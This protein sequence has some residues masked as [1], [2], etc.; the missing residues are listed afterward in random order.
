MGK[1][2]Y[3]ISSF[4]FLQSRTSLFDRFIRDCKNIKEILVKGKEVE[5]DIDI[6]LELARLRYPNVTKEHLNEK[7]GKH[8]WLVEEAVTSL[9]T[10]YSQ[11]SDVSHFKRIQDF[12][13]QANVILGL[14]DDV[15]IRVQILENFCWILD[16]ILRAMDDKYP[17]EKEEYHMEKIQQFCFAISKMFMPLYDDTS[18]CYDTGESH[19]KEMVDFYWFLNMT[20]TSMK[21]KYPHETKEFDIKEM[22]EYLWFV[23]MTF[24]S[25]G[26]ID[27][28]QVKKIKEY[29]GIK[30][31][32]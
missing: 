21:T 13:M 32:A 29:W 5:E 17:N 10:R 8:R 26:N 4:S 12:C 23:D 27:Q 1:E 3:T 20:L 25:S 24:N 16:M 2:G 28:A 14:E 31:N 15:S 30:G 11:E 19:V 9:K 7:I 22:E 18:G 6:D